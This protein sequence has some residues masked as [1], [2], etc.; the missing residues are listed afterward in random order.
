MNFSFCTMPILSVLISIQGLKDIFF[1]KLWTQLQHKTNF[2]T[3]AEILSLDCLPHHFI[4][5]LRIG[6]LFTCLVFVFK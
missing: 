3:I 5:G 2:S 4:E 6:L 1:C